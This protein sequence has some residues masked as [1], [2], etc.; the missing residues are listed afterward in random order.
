MNFLVYRLLRLNHGLQRWLTKQLTPSGLCLLGGLFVFGLI[1][2]DMR[3]S[4]SYQI[5]AFLLAAL[6]VSAVLSR[7]GRYRFSATRKLPRF[8]TVGTPLKY[9]IVINNQTARRN[10]KP[11]RGLR[12][13]ESTDSFPDF[14][15]YRAYVRRAQQRE[16]KLIR[17]LASSFLDF[18]TV[19]RLLRQSGVRSDWLRLLKQRRWMIAPSVALPLLAAQG[20]TEVMSEV[21]PLRRGLLRFQTLTLAL[22]EPL[23]LVNR[24]FSCS[25]PQSVLILPRR[26]E[27]PAI[28]FPGSRRY[29]ADG[30]TIAASVGDSEEFRALRDYRPGDS[31][32]KI[33]WKSW[34][35]QGRPVIKEEQ[36]EYSVRHAL[37][38]DTFQAED[39]SEVMEAA[40]AIA[41]SFACT[42]QTQESLLD[43]VFVSGEAH[44]FTTGRSL[45]QTE[46]L[47][48]LL[49]SVKPCQDRE[50]SSLW[51]VVRS[52]LS[53]LSGCICI[54][55][56][57][58]RDRQTLVEQLQ[59]AGIPVLGLI[60]APA[61]G[62][63]E[64]PDQ[65]CLKDRQSRLQ[66]LTMDNIQ[67][68]LLAL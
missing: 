15:T 12:L 55:L 18:R 20:E 10:A 8:G 47:L 36:A 17:S 32:R 50:F 11:Q 65:S 63:P 29:Q 34:A 31:P 3:R 59:T 56:T 49:A 7:F 42:I 45:G 40:V 28:Q 19:A 33:H 14:R 66:V 23:G 4:I 52:R 68:G 2:L 13:I 27:L 39:Y 26:Y 46:Q 41:L 43:T 44:C 62:L 22:P 57:W 51:P 67:A 64:P 35:K 9:R 25:A 37:I 1:G 54:F 6:L 5:F 24:C 38:L 58:D 21:M 61:E 53:L 30:L 60:V 16:S 48:E